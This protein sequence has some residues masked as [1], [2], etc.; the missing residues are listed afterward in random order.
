[1]AAKEDAECYIFV[2]NSNL[3]IPGQEASAKKLV[4][5]DTDSRFRVDLGKFLQLITKERHIAKAFLYGS[6]KPP[7]NDSIWKAARKHNF[8]VK[9]FPRSRGGREKEVDVAMTLGIVENLYTETKENAVFIVVTGDRD[10][11]SPIEKVLDNGVPV[12]LWSWER[13]MARDFCK[14]ANT[15]KLFT[16][17]ALDSVQDSFSFTAI[18][19]TLEPTDVDPAHT[20]VY[21]D[22]PG[23]KQFVYTLAD[24][25]SRLMRLFY[26]SSIEKESTQDL[27]M[28]FPNSTQN[29]VL[30]K[31]DVLEFDYQPCS[32]PEYLKSRKHQGFVLKL[33]NRFKA[34]TGIDTDDFESV[35]EAV[36]ASMRTKLE[37]M[38]LGSTTIGEASTQEEE[39]VGDFDDWETEVR[40]KVGKMTN[41]RRRKEI[42]CRWGDHCAVA[43]DCPYKHTEYEIK[44][45]TKFPN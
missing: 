3:W 44:L 26:I 31:L 32:Y 4:D 37:D 42:K 28:Q 30:K 20:I 1:M 7:P 41:N 34:L 19:S 15:H 21:K 36:E 10:L 5:A 33:T 39:S 43:F 45:F 35:L 24:H 13:A 14:L 9:D 18:K 12:E 16:A 11:K 40:R 38:S 29:V 6:V 2:D 27:I 17:S 23:G 25:I 22:V 8:E